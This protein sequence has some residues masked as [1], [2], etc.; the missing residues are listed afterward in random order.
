MGENEKMYYC[1]LAGMYCKKVGRE[2]IVKVARQ[3]HFD[4]AGKK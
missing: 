2:N 1:R 3:M 4:H